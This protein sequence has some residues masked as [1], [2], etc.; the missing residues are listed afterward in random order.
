MTKKDTNYFE[1]DQFYNTY[2][3]EYTNK[4]FDNNNEEDDKSELDDYSN[5][6]E[7]YAK[8]I[9]FNEYENPIDKSRNTDI[10]NNSIIQNL[11]INI[12]SPKSNNL[13]LFDITNYNKSAQLS[14]INIKNDIK[15]TNNR[16][17]TEYLTILMMNQ[18][19]KENQ[20]KFEQESMN[21]NKKLRDDNSII[22]IKRKISKDFYR[23]TNEIIKIF[24]IK[25]C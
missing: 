20:I 7:K 10:N 5:S 1:D 4:I 21:I 17:E 9:F 12:I 11:N 2:N 19:D 23:E 14:N 22:K 3:I 18:K 24:F 25:I 13:N 6:E 8:R 15:Q 16:I